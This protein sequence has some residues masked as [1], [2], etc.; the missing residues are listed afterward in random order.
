MLNCIQKCL[1]E[2]FRI[3]F[4]QISGHCGPAK[5]THKIN[6]HNAYGRLTHISLEMCLQQ[7]SS[8]SLQ[9]VTGAEPMGWTGI[10]PG[11][12]ELSGKSYGKGW[13]GAA[14]TAS[15]HGFTSELCKGKKTKELWAQGSWEGSG[16]LGCCCVPSDK[17]SH[18]GGDSSAL[19]LQCGTR[20]DPKKARSRAAVTLSISRI[21]L[22]ESFLQGSCYPHK[23]MH[24]HTHTHTPAHTPP[25]T[26]LHR[27]SCREG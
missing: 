18:R 27:L 16:P 15:P 6:Y 10:G 20:I 21:I 11:G 8:L 2:T 19:S 17:L 26:Q 3:I 23:H 13:T 5:L 14:R 7:G 12:L 24:T 4:D 9:R 25:H 22:I 1:T